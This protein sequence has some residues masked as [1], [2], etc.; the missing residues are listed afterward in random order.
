MIALRAV[1]KRLRNQ[2][3]GGSGEFVQCGH[4]LEKGGGFQ[5]RTSAL[6]GIDIGDEGR[7]HWLLQF[8]KF[9]MIR[10]KVKL[11]GQ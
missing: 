6:F 8:N 10:A 2:Q 7:G 9:E 1:H 11:F 5:I 3:G 4:F